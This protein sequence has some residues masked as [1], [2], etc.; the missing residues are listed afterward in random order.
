MKKTMLAAGI[1]ASVAMAGC[2]PIEIGTGVGAATGGTIGLL[3]T[4][5]LGGIAVGTLL[6][7]AGGYVVGALVQT[8][9][10]GV[11]VVRDENGRLLFYDR[12]GN[13]VAYPT[14]DPVTASC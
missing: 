6:G 1:A 4:G 5:T 3:T 14:L 13:V 2:T 11:C 8:Q 12:D 9:N 7:G 10:P